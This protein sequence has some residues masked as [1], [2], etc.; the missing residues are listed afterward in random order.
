VD[1][2]LEDSDRASQGF[3]LLNNVAIGAAYALNVHRHSIGRVAIID[4]D[5]HHG[6]GTEALVRGLAGPKTKV[7]PIMTGAVTGYLEQHTFCPWLDPHTDK[8]NVFFASVHRYD[9]KFYPYSGATNV[10]RSVVDVGFPSGASSEDLRDAFM[11]MILPRLL[12]FSPDMIFISAGFDGHKRDRLAAGQCEFDEHDY[13][14]MT[15]QLLAVARECGHSR[16]VSVLEG[17]YNTRAGWLSPFSQAV[18]AHV[19]ALVGSHATKS[20]ALSQHSVEMTTASTEDVGAVDSRTT[21]GLKRKRE[22]AELFGE[23]SAQ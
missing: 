10:E 14:W 8:D 5:V 22:E 2:D 21:I 13:Y 23:E 15:E 16:V 7:I 20:L 11:R 18:T 1:R 19:R 9:G 4:F 12:A 17:G 3:C 6:N